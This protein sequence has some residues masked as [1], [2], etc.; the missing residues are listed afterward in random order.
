MTQD[1]DF[2]VIA[3][4]WLRE[5]QSFSGI[6]FGS[7]ANLTIGTAINDIHLLSEAL[8]QEELINS[9]VYLPL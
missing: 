9:I 8:T 1:D 5:G 4:Q 7:Q 3:A 6:V 2:L